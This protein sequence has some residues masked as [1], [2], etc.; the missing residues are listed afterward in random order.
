MKYEMKKQNETI[1][2]YLFFGF[3]VNATIHGNKRMLQ[4]LIILRQIK[5]KKE[6]M[7]CDSL[8]LMPKTAFVTL[9][10]SS[11]FFLVYIPKKQWQCHQQ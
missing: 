11:L 10:F 8:G 5:K 4:A 2:T 9:P 3:V 1:L 6:V 7:F